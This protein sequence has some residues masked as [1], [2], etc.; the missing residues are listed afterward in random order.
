HTP[1]HVVTST[2]SLHDALP[3]SGNTAPPFNQSGGVDT[4]I[5]L[6]KSLVLTGYAAQTRSP[7]VTGGQTNLG[8]GLNYKTSWLEFLAERRKRSEEHTSEL[9]SLAFMVCS[10]L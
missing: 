3:I 8:A 9:Q 2:L 5:V 6:M 4:R 10:F 1:P 7:L